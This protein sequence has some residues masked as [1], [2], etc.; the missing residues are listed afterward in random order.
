M[1]SANTSCLKEKM[2]Q[3]KK[4]CTF[5]DGRWHFTER[6]C[7]GEPFVIEQRNWIRS[8]G[9]SWLSSPGAWI[10]HPKKEN[11]YVWLKKGMCGVLLGCTI[12]EISKASLI[13]VEGC[14]SEN[15]Y[16]YSCLRE[17]HPAT[18]GQDL[19]AC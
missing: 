13:C 7:A 16:R 5:N 6:S 18:A 10:G 11:S 4:S 3:R 14:S 15:Q 2:L 8:G 19:A 12:T 9:N 1:R 17:A